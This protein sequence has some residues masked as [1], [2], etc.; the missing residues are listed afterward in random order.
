MFSNVLDPHHFIN[1]IPDYNYILI[2]NH[3]FSVNYCPP[4]SLGYYSYIK[5]CI[6]FLKK[7]FSDPVIAIYIWI[8][9][10][11]SSDS[12]LHFVWLLCIFIGDKNSFESKWRTSYALRWNLKF[13]Q[14]RSVHFIHL[15]LF[16]IKSPWLHMFVLCVWCICVNPKHV[17]LPAGIKLRMYN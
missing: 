13:R 8:R 1:H 16:I 10:L 6:I 9:Y 3:P 14:I 2:F 7:S 12:H 5:I 4:P 15:K 17:P 11:L